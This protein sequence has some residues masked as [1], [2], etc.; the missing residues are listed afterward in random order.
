MALAPYSPTGPSG[1]SHRPWPGPLR[2]ARQHRATG[3]ISG[4][5]GAFLGEA[6]LAG[7]LV[8]RTTQHL[9]QLQHHAA[10]GLFGRVDSEL[11]DV[12]SKDEL[13][14]DQV[15]ALLAL[16]VASAI[17]T[18][19]SGVA[20]KPGGETRAMLGVDGRAVVKSDLERCQQRGVA[21]VHVHRW[22]VGQ[23]PIKERHV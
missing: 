3:T 15:H 21:R 18:D 22:N 1:S 6:L 8:E 11:S 4:P 20:P 14:I 5:L 9:E 10:V 13:G 23:L 19:A 16:D 12:V 2:A 7:V 17:F